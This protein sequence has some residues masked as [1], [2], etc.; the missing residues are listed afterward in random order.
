[1]H[2]LPSEAA[3]EELSFVD[4]LDGSVCH[5]PFG[6]R[7]SAA[8]TTYPN[9]NTACPAGMTE[10]SEALSDDS[11]RD[12]EAASSSK[13][14][15]AYRRRKDRLTR[16]TALKPETAFERFK[17]SFS[18]SKASEAIKA[19]FANFGKDSNRV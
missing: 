15:S 6:S 14:A 7:Q 12:D 13:P 10:Q 16:Q 4:G 3:C 2:S 11:G 8:S 17:S 9:G 5:G 19:R 1:M 18:K